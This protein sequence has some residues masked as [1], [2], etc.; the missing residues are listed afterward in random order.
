MT[1][2]KDHPLRLLPGRLGVT[3]LAVDSELPIW[4]REGV[5]W[6]AVRTRQELSIVCEE[7]FVPP[8]VRSERGWRGL[9]V[10]GQL[11][12][13]LLGILAGIATI[14][15]EAGV[16]IFVISTYDTDYVMVKESAL[17][18]ALNALKRAGYLIIE[19][20]GSG[21]PDVYLPA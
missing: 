12:F 14:L 15:A 4:A 11:D 2:P 3:R 17:E 8:E 19:T 16:S 9:Q 13:S 1:T 5:L 20:V 6:A 7:R 21:D 18:R 10:E